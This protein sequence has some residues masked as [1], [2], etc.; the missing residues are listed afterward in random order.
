MEK[1]IVEIKNLGKKYNI[2]HQKGGYI[3]LR[4]TLTNVIRR[5]LHF[6]KQKAKQVVGLESKE[7]FW[8]L[9]NINID[10]QRGETIGVI[11]PNGA[12]KSTLLKILSKITPPTT[13]EVVLRGKVASLLEV[14]TGFHPELTGR[15]NIFLNAAILGMT[16]HEIAKKFDQIVEFSGVEKFID[17]PVKRYSSG[18]Y[19]RLAFA[20]AA[21]IEPDILIVDE[22]LA[23]GDS[24]FQKKSLGKM[25]EITKKSGR[26]ILFVSHNMSAVRNICNRTI[27]IQDGQVKMIGPTEQVVNSYLDSKHEKTAVYKFNENKNKDVE[28]S[29]ISFL[30]GNNRP[31]SRFAISENFNIE[32][33]YTTYK[34]FENAILTTYFINN[35]EILMVSTEVDKTGKMGIHP[36]GKH[37]TTITVPPFLFNVGHYDIE[38]LFDKPFAGSIDYKKNMGFE[39]TDTGNPRS[40]LYKGNHPG[41]IFYR[42]DYKTKKIN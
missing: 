18:M 40:I 35:G 2:T 31:S 33:E 22:V 36:I 5:P 32:I 15:E 3:T 8:A 16:R 17:T 14:G 21:H 24:E 42:L 13:G 1:P 9:K 6:T 38:V 25:E 41:R 23:V 30:D 34:E 4:D 37:Q 28:I 11:G 12:G 19:V 10:I 39:I 20:V 27:L 26:T 29:K 7:E